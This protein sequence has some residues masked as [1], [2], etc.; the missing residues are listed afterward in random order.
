MAQTISTRIID[1]N[2]GEHDNPYELPKE[3]SEGFLNTDNV[4]YTHTNPATKLPEEIEKFEYIYQHFQD[5]KKIH[6]INSQV[7][8]EQE[9]FQINHDILLNPVYICC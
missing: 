4:V 5:C 6:E 7:Q 3:N 9:H 2:N 8:T 1:I